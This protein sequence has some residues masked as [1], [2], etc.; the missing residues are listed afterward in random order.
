M[1]FQTVD[2]VPSYRAVTRQV[3]VDTTVEVQSSVLR[4][5]KAK[6]TYYKPKTR[7]VRYY[8]RI[9]VVRHVRTTRNVP[10]T[11]N[12]PTFE[13]VVTTHYVSPPVAVPVP[14][15]VPVHDLRSVNVCSA[16]VR[17]CPGFDDDCSRAYAREVH[18]L[19]TTAG[20]CP[21]GAGVCTGNGVSHGSYATPWQVVY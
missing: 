4:K 13:P 5:R 15:H 1:S 19:R 3:P 8:E 12:E 2:Y 16:T 7:T 14:V 6:E 9:P 11:T 21:I 10:V 17:R 20:Y 18:D